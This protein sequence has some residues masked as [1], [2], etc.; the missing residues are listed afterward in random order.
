MSENKKSVYRFRKKTPIPKKHE[1]LGIGDAM[2]QFVKSLKK[3]HSYNEAIISKVWGE[4]MGHTIASRTLSIKLRGKVLYVKLN[5][6]S[7][8]N[9][10][11]MARE[12]VVNRINQRLRTEVLTEVKF[13]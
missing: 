12:H 1:T 13:T 6:P 8:K 4:V 7:L 9:E 2:Q 3:S 10:L 5:A 11:N